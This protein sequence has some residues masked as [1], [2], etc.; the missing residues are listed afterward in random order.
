MSDLTLANIHSYYVVAGTTPV[1]VHN[2]GEATVYLDPSG[3]PFHASLQISAESHTEL[4]GLRTARVRNYTGEVPSGTMALRIPLPD[5]EGAAE[6][7]SR[8]LNK[9][10][11]G[12]Y[13]PSSK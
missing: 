12:P 7:V 6:Y 13:N 11:V 1:L 4:V 5:P 2:C 8:Q 3:S 9:P 10:N